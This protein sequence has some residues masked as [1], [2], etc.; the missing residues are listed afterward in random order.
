MKCLF[1]AAGYATRLYPLTENFPKPLLPIKDKPLLDYLI[2]DLD[3]GG[4]IDEYIV[5]TNHKYFNVFNEWATKHHQKIKIIDDGTLSNETRLGAV[6]DIQLVINSL[7][8]NEDILILAGDNLLDFSLNDFIKYSLEKD[9]SCIMRFN[10]PDF[11]KIKRS[12]NLIVDENDKVLTML[13]KPSAPQ[14][15]WCCPPFYF[16]KKEDIVLIDSCLKERGN[17]DSPGAFA[18]Y[19]VSHSIVHAY[20]MPGRR[21]DIGSKEDYLNINKDSQL[22]FK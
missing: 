1:L 19:V 17:V 10:E 6:K 16:Y 15:H 13:E 2:D 22:L 9:T 8:L 14:T 11:E 5:I 3:K 21:F 20:K 4:Y 7:K 18:S 12:A